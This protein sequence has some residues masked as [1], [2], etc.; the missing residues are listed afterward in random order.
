[1]PAAHDGFMFIVNKINDGRIGPYHIEVIL[2]DDQN[3]MAIAQECWERFA[4]Q[5]P[6]QFVV[7]GQT[8]LT[9]AAG[10]YF[11]KF[12][13]LNI[14]YELLNSAAATLQTDS[15]LRCCTGPNSVYM[16]TIRKWM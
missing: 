2:C 3:I 8:T 12:G 1:M 7:G 14:Q 9:V 10:N 16:S 5:D 11:E 4:I 15:Y 13:I 6:V